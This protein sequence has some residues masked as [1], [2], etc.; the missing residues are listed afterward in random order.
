MAQTISVPIRPAR[1]SRPWILWLLFFFQFAAVGIYFSYLNIYYR[2]AGLSGTQI[3]VMNMITALVGVVSAIFWGYLSD[4]TGKARYLIAFGATGALIINQF[5]PLVSTFWAFLGLG[6]VANIFGAASYTLVDS[7]AMALLGDNR[8]NYGAYRVGGSIGYIITSLSAGYLYDWAGMRVMFPAYGILM[9]MFAI[10]AL[11]LPQVQ[12]K[13]STSS[14]GKNR[15][16]TS[17][18]R[19]PAW[20]LF[21]LCIFLVSIASNA[22]ISFL[23]VSLDEMGAKRSLIGWV[24]TISAIAEVPFMAFSGWFL[25]RFGLQRLLLISIFLMMVRNFLLGIMQAPE[26]AV[27]INWLNGPAY[28]LFWNSAVNYANRL[29]PEGYTATA[30]GMLNS[31]TSLAGMV[32]ALLAG[33]LFDQ[34]G[35]TRLFLVTACFCLTAFVLF[36]SGTR[37]LARAPKEATP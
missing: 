30:Q 5:I 36:A 28:A 26:W 4:R 32:S 9:V 13:R 6:I 17:L 23:G 19:L 3:G 33:W 14:T 27:A 18:L 11:L 7:T 16:I 24:V 1:N 37:Y 35:A 12:V 2:D 22:A 10:T 8:E 29:A 34:V 25:R 31:T 15:G 20:V 21:T